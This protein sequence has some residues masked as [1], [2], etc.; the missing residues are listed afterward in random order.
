VLGE[1]IARLT[2]SPVE[3]IPVWLIVLSTVAVGFLLTAALHPKAPRQLI[4]S[5]A[6]GMTVAGVLLLLAIALF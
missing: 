3:G 4:A 2:Y 6:L 5:L 1:R